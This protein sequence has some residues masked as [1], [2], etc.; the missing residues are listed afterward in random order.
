MT[1]QNTM[2]FFSL[3][4]PLVAQ[5]NSYISVV[6]QRFDKKIMLT[7]SEQNGTSEVTHALDI[8][9]RY[10]LLDDIK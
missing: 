8:K 6:V 9:Y 3:N 2:G 5:L 1:T 4:F 10:F 7:K